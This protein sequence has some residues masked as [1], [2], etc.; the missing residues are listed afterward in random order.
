MQDFSLVRKGCW[1]RGELLLQGQGCSSGFQ[2][3]VLFGKQLEAA[4]YDLD[5]ALQS[6][7]R[8]RCAELL[9]DGTCPHLRC[10]P[11]RHPAGFM[12]LESADQLPLEQAP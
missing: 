11:I 9:P 5:A 1:L 4:S 3:S 7:N 10:F 8:S 6:Y 2:D 12:L